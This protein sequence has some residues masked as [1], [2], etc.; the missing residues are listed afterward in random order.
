MFPRQKERYCKQPRWHPF[1]IFVLVADAKYARV[2]YLS[3]S[4]LLTRTTGSSR[5]PSN[6][7]HQS[8]FCA[9]YLMRI[10]H[11]PT[12]AWAFINGDDYTVV[13]PSRVGVR[14]F[15]SAPEL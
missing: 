13:E 14:V 7:L 5:L 3:A 4:S 12:P 6:A 15:Q 10:G 9:E 11:W 2:K 8:S 1:R